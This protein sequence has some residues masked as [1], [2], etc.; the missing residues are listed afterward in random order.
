MSSLERDFVGES[1]RLDLVSMLE[2][3]GD[4]ND[5]DYLRSQ[6][7]RN[8]KLLAEQSHERAKWYNK[9]NSLI[10]GFATSQI[11]ER[12]LAKKVEEL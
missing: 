2:Q 3:Y 1:A 10:D 9:A 11:N 12:T 6:L 7:L 8:S 5:P 4:P